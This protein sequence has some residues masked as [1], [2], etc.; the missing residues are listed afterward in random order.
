MFLLTFH[1]GPTLP[2]GYETVWKKASAYKWQKRGE[3]L[4]MLG[5]KAVLSNP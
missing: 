4:P 3:K 1:A 5:M 2:I